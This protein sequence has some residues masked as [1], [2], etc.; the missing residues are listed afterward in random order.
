MKNIKYILFD[1]DGTLLPMETDD[2]IKLYFSELTKKFTP[3]KFDS[4]LVIEG[5][6]Y[7]LKEMYKDKSDNLN[8]IHFWKGFEEKTTYLKDEVYDIFTDFYSNEFL[9]LGEYCEDKGYSKLI[10]NELNEKGYK[11]ILATNPLFPMVAQM[12]R[13]GL[14]GLNEDDFE[15]VTSMEN[16]TKLK[17]DYLYFEEIITKL[18][19]NKEEVIMIGNDVSDD[20]FAAKKAG[21]KGILITDHL[22][23]NYQMD[24]TEFEKYSL[25]EFYQ[26]IVKNVNAI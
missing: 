8:H 20:M 5:I 12:S 1:L 22:L 23:N 14:V 3:T 21:I 19:I 10:V 13:A 16:S 4:K 26:Q 7:G 2:F 15:Y 24:D 6:N 18:N 25:K 9:K 11:L 17:P